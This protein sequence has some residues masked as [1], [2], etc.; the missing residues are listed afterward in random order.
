MDTN[1][2]IIYNLVC[3]LCGVETTT[4][5]HEVDIKPLFCPMCGCDVQDEE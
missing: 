5:V 2:E 3:E 4:E 1:I